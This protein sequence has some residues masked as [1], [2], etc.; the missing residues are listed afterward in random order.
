MNTQKPSLFQQFSAKFTICLAMTI[1][2]SH[3]V[4]AQPRPAQGRPAQSDAPSLQLIENF[5]QVSG[6]SL[7]HRNLLNVV[8]SG[9]IKESIQERRF[10]LIETADGR[11]LITYDWVHLG[12]AHQVVYGHDGEQ[13][14][15]QVRKPQIEEPV[16][17]SGIEGRH[18]AQVLWLLQP[19]TL[20]RKGDYIFQFEGNAKVKGRPAFLVKGFGAEERHAWFYFDREN[21]LL[22]RWGAIGAIA[23]AEAYMD[24]QATRFKGVDGLL[25]PTAIEL[26]VENAVFG[27]VTFDSIQTNQDLSDISF[28]APE[29]ELPTLRQRP[30]SSD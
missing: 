15:K 30:I 7:A 2:L 1:L 11:R 24:Y 13:T 6:G 3:L 28:Q 12:R 21:S 22:T 25:F 19:F 26:V 29:M 5:L 4:S 27:R 10:K 14:W 8:A 9:Q 23:G 18:F 20:P 16:A 17:Y